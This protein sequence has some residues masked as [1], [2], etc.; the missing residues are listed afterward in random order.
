MSR[1]TLQQLTLAFEI[2]IAIIV[3]G[4]GD[5]GGDDEVFSKNVY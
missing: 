2:G 5:D 1:G 3:V 4:C